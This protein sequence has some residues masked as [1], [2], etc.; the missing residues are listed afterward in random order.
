MVLVSQEA[1][2][3]SLEAFLPSNEF[4]KISLDDYIGEKW[5]LLFF[6]PF[7]FTFVCP[8]EIIAFSN[9]IEEFEKRD[10]QILGCSVD[11]KFAHRVW[12]RMT[13]QEGGI[14]NIKF[15]LL[16]DVSKTCAESYNVLHK[17]GMALRGTFLI[18]KSGLLQASSTYNSSIGRSIE[19]TLRMIDACQHYEKYGEVCPA[20]WKKGKKAM[21][22][23]PQGI[24]E[25]LT[26]GKENH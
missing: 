14:G 19:E 24:S 17:E 10:V 23:S 9:Y 8:S 6:Y 12:T 3:F 5:V 18:D 16:A 1:P 4:G 2:K 21:K 25:Y 13:P 26:N 22:P 20:N 15:P 7:D 11:S